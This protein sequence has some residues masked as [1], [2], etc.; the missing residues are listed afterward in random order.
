MEEIE[1]IKNS[2]VFAN[3]SSNDIKYTLENIH[4]SFQHFDKGEILAMQDEVCNRLIILVNGRIKAE[5]ADASGKVVKVE[6]ISAPNPLAIL[7][8]FGKENRF[9]VQVT[10]IEK[11]QTLIIPKQAVLKMLQLN[12]QIL[13]NYLN[14]SAQYASML[15]RKLH[16]MSFRSIR[17]KLTMYFLELTKNNKT[18]A[19][20]EL[21][22]TALA[23]YFGVSRPSLARELSNMQNEGL[24][25]IVDRKR[26]TIPDRDKLIHLV[27]F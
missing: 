4:Y 11:V 5:M 6:D 26:I 25:I 2:P 9:P 21:T 27:S 1:L 7:F 14:I 3:L 15:S 22:Q 16:F 12:E 19:E 18:Y 8:L 24:I 17:Q 13:T 10:A 23:E 20:M